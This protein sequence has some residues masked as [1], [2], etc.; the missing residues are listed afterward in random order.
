MIENHLTVPDSNHA[1]RRS[2]LRFLCG[3]LLI[4]CFKRAESCSCSLSFSLSSFGRGRSKAVAWGEPM[5][6]AGSDGSCWL[7]VGKSRTKDDD[8]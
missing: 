4:A 2:P 3:S 5:G 1:D 8:D 7:S 6:T